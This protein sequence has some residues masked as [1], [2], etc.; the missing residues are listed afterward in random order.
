MRTLAPGHLP[1]YG[2]ISLLR[3]SQT[4]MTYLHFC[5]FAYLV[6]IM[7]VSNYVITRKLSCKIS[8]VKLTQLALKITSKLKQTKL[9][10]LDFIKFTANELQSA[11]QNKKDTCPTR[12]LAPYDPT[13]AL[14]QPETQISTLAFPSFVFLS[15]IKNIILRQKNS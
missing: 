5:I 3:Y 2:L 15:A 11:N 13:L 12:T 9:S 8:V 6:S 14:T 4:G 1:Q 10:Y 7:N